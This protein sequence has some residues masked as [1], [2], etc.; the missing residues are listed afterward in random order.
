MAKPK[1]LKYYCKNCCLEFESISK[2][3]NCPRCNASSKLVVDAKQR[4]LGGV[5]VSV[6][7]SSGKKL[8]RSQHDRGK[9]NLDGKTVKDC[10]SIDREKNY[11]RHRILGMGENGKVIDVYDRPELLDEH[12]RRKKFGKR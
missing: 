8:I 11:Y 6:F 2:P 4:F 7:D 12:N 3:L 5:K 10:I 1:K 9:I